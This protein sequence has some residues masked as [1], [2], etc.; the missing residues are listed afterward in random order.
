MAGGFKV[1]HLVKPFQRLMP[2]IEE[3]LRK[4]RDG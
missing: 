3:P 4:V 2:E 1:L